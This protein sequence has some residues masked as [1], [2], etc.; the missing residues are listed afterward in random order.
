[1]P[2]PIIAMPISDMTVRTSA[3]STLIRPGRVIRSAMPCTAPSSTSFAARNALRKLTSRPSTVSSFSFGIVMSESTWCDELL[4]A[5]Q[6]DLHAPA[7][8]ERERLGHD[9][10]REDA[11]LLRELRDDR[12]GARAGAAAHAGGDEHHVG[13]VQHLADALAVLERGLAPDFRIRARAEPLGH[14]VRRAAAR[15]SPGSA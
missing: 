14:V 11:H 9:R 1:M 4:D 5:L 15:S 13:A 3:K 8:L 7:A 6:R 10:D 12:R 2:E